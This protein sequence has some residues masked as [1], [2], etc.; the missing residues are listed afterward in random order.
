MTEIKIG[1]RT[2]PLSYSTYELIAIQRKI[3]CTG[4]E[5]KDKVFGIRQENE[6]DPK[7]IRLDVIND[8]DRME[9][10]GKLIAILGNA[11]LEEQGK[12]P[13]LTEK[14][15][16]RNMKPALILGYAVAVMAEISNGNIM[17]SKEEEDDKPKDVILEAEQAKKQQG[18]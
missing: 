13:N 2:V 10:L 16:L 1:G 18:S 14:W 11:G 5:L 9:R 12:E 15:V 8:P 7:S 4:F 17:E 6:D 3:G